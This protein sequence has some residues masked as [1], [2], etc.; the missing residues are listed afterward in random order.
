MNITPDFDPTD[1]EQIRALVEATV[2]TEEAT[3]GPA[4]APVKKEPSRRQVRF[5]GLGELLAEPKPPKW[6]IHRYL[7]ESSLACLFGASGTMKSFVALDMGLCLATGTPWHGHDVGEPGPVFYVCGEGFNGVARRIQA[8]LL[9]NHAD[10]NTTPFYVSSKPVEFLNSES[11]TDAMTAIDGLSQEHGAP[12]IIIIDTLARCFGPGDENSTRDMNAFVAAMDEVKNKFNC[13]VLV[14]HHTGLAAGDRGRGSSAL[15][16]GLD[17]EYKL[18]T[19]NDL[20]VLSCTKT[21]DGAKLPDIPFR[22]EVVDTGWNDEYG[23]AVTSVVL[24]ETDSPA[25]SYRQASLSGGKKIALESLESLAF[26]KPDGRVHIDA[27]RNDAY[28]RGITPSAEQEAKK[29]AFQRAVRGLLDSGHIQTKDD[30]YW[31]TNQTG[32]AGHVP[33]LSRCPDRDGTGHTPKGCPGC[34]DGPARTSV[35]LIDPVTG[36]KQ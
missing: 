6:L 31:P 21:K 28:R 22:Y 16:G 27:W 1:E 25:T 7:E 18:E 36:V 17:F 33:G 23:D 5:I 15:Y 26:Q 8:W 4:E 2:A 29:K 11:L 3:Y 24:H 34:P 10:P 9:S 14:V 13:T 19:K 32:Q 20:R 35:P 30:L 12:R